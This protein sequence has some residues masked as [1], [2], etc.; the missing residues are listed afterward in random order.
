VIPN[1]I[2]ARY[3]P[4]IPRSKND[5]G[6]YD[7][8]GTFHFNAKYKGEAISNRVLARDI[9]ECR[10]SDIEW[11]WI[12]EARRR[13]TPEEIRQLCSGNWKGID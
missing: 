9:K 7:P 3:D 5:S 1:L 10:V 2:P 8:H 11:I 12:V 6:L 4:S 13:A